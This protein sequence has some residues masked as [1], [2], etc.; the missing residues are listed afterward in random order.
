MDDFVALFSNAGHPVT[1]HSETSRTATT[2]PSQEHSQGD[3]DTQTQNSGTTSA[4]RA[5]PR[6]NIGS[7]P[8]NSNHQ[9]PSVPCESFHFGPRSRQPQ[10]AQTGGNNSAQ[11]NQSD[12]LVQT[13]SDAVVSVI[14]DTMSGRT[15]SGTRSGQTASGPTG[16]PGRILLQ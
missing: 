2:T 13:F 15:S 9:D 11:A 7:L 12:G 14:Q 6:I 1:S 3:T 5:I 8:L 10:G 4:S 16:H